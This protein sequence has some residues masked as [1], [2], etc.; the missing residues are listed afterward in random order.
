MSTRT[1]CGFT[2]Y[3]LQIILYNICSYKVKLNA[4]VL[5][6]KYDLE[7]FLKS[8]TILVHLKNECI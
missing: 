1:T 8:P 5:K 6:H 7:L 3:Y 2:Y 4:S